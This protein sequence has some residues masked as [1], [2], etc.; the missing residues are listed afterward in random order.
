MKEE[1]I[2]VIE[3]EYILWTGFTFVKEDEK[4]LPESRVLLTVNMPLT[5]VNSITPVKDEDF[6]QEPKIKM[7]NGSDCDELSCIFRIPD[8]PEKNWQNNPLEM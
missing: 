2:I 3:H 7:G 8:S 5:V 4:Q 1:V 6:P